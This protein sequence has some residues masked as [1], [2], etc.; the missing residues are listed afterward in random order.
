MTEASKEYV[1][2]CVFVPHVCMSITDLSF[3]ATL[4][5]ER[6]HPMVQHQSKAE[7]L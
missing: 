2:L 5:L 6:V 4:F 3:A 1:L 7:G